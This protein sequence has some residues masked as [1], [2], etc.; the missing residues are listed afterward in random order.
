MLQMHLA[1]YRSEETVVTTHLS[2][3][4]DELLEIPGVVASSTFPFSKT[5]K[6]FGNLICSC[7]WAK[8]WGSAY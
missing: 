4:V 1:I 2:G 5:T 8:R 3:Y 6:S 7:P